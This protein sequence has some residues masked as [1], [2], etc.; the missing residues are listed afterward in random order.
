MK[1]RQ[2]NFFMMPLCFALCFI[3][4]VGLF[5]VVRYL[6][7]HA[8]YAQ[9]K[10]N[11][12][13]KESEHLKKQIQQ[14]DHLMADYQGDIKRFETLL[15]NEKDIAAFLEGISGSSKQYKIKLKEMTALQIEQVKIKELPSPKESKHVS[16]AKTE[17]DEGM[18]LMS[19]PYKIRIAGETKGVFDFMTDLE[20][21]KQ[22]LTLSDFHIV[23]R[24]Y[25]QIQA[26]FRLD[27]YSLSGLVRE[28]TEK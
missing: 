18:Y 17:K 13:E 2:R 27:L 10:I 12:L 16:R 9:Q 5:S 15:F 21:N 4:A 20:K 7:A 26:E 25:P 22:L 3:F 28:Q 1:P 14:L 6:D 19:S 24:M 11:S 8:S 23:G